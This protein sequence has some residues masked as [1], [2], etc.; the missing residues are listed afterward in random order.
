MRSS[1]SRSVLQI[2]SSTEGGPQGPP[3][4]FASASFCCPGETIQPHGENIMKKITRNVWTRLR[5]SAGS[6]AKR[7]LL[8][9]LIIGSGLFPTASDL[10]AAPQLKGDDY[11]VIGWNDLGMH[12]INPS[13]KTLALLP[14][15]NNLWVQV[16]K[17]GRPAHGRYVGNHAGIFNRQQLKG[18][19]ENGFLAVRA[20]ALRRQSSG[21]DRADG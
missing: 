16:I 13:Y 12:C 1:R 2:R 20:A 9:L 11:V 17:R 18:K 8:M 6:L 7:G 14:P 3:F 5:P 15:Y 19:R 21:R 10:L 4:P